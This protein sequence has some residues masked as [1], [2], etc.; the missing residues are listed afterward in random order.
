MG[1]QVRN[2]ELRA[3]E[4]NGTQQQQRLEQQGA[5]TARGRDVSERVD[6]DGA[7]AV[8]APSAR[9]D[10]DDR[11]R[12]QGNGNSAQ[13]TEG[14]GRGHPRARDEENGSM[15]RDQGGGQGGSEIARGDYDRG[16][17]EARSLGAT[18]G[19][20][21]RWRHSPQTARDV[22]T[23]NPKSVRPGDPVTQIA[24]LMVDEDAGIIPVVDGG[25]LVGVVTDRDIVCRMVVAG[26]DP[27]TVKASDVMSVDVECVTER[28][29]LHEVLQIMGEHQVRRVPVVA[30]DDRLVGIISMADLAR[31]AD[32]DEQLQG[33]FEEISSER[34]FWSQLR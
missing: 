23:R 26:T 21:R 22:M 34:N 33:A 29:S 12:A 25:K 13:P 24:Q 32:V 4:T 10:R 19:G 20:R 7:R 5:S 11:Q 3:N 28:D 31:E 9:A 2:E 16:D 8:Q 17:Q 18:Q 30:K 15:G 27:K 1:R 6:A 14:N